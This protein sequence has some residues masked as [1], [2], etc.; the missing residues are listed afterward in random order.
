MRAHTLILTATLGALAAAMA[1]AGDLSAS[2][3][4]TVRVM[5]VDH[6]GRPPFQREFVEV[7]V[8]DLAALEPVAEASS[9]E[10]VEMLVTDFR[11]RPPYQRERMDVP[12]ADIAAMEV[13]EAT[14]PKTQFRGRPPF[15][16]H[17]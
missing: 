3:G 4:E 9:G 6:S 2:A 10:T 16:R 5:K 8:A 12:V 14:A 17:R 1:Q 11:G 15:N 7:P 13:A